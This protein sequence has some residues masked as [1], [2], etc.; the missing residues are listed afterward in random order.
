MGKNLRP[1]RIESGRG[2]SVGGTLSSGSVVKEGICRMLGA[3]ACGK[4]PE[5]QN[6]EGNQGG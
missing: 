1:R 5:M 6:Q 2:P 4:I 3:L